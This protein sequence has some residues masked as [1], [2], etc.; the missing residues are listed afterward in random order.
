[1]IANKSG[2]GGI[3][4]RRTDW[5][6]AAMG[7]DDSTNHIT[8]GNF[9]SRQKVSTSQMD[10]Q[11]ANDMAVAANSAS[12]L[13]SF[14]AKVIQLLAGFG[15]PNSKQTIWRLEVVATI[16]SGLAVSVAACACFGV[17]GGRELESQGM[18]CMSEHRTKAQPTSD[19]T[20]SLECTWDDV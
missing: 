12:N 16:D 10:G 8:R 17:L 5:D 13:A 7:C 19:D 1:M 4:Y 9:L 3:N 14:T 15:S 6:G 11:L 2:N 20:C 18:A